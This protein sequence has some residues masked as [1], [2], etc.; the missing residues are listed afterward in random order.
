VRFGANDS[1]RAATACTDWRDA[2]TSAATSL[3]IASFN[4]AITALYRCS[5]TD[6]ATNANAGLPPKSDRADH[7]QRRQAGP[8]TQLSNMSRDRTT[9]AHSYW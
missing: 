4:T 2:P 5:T 1:T 6:N 7:G 8:E 9:P 3:T